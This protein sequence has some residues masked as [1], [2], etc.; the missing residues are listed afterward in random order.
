MKKIAKLLILAI[1]CT[2]CLVLVACDKVDSIYF[3]TEPR[4]NYVQGQDFTLE[5]AVLMA[6]SGNKKN[7]VNLDEATY[8]GYNPNQIGE[9]TVT[10][11]YEGQTVEIKVTVIP[12]IA[13]EGIT[14]DYFVGDNFD[15][16][17]GRLRV[18]DDKANVKSVNLSE[19]AV[20]IEGFD[21]STT[22]QKTLTVKYG[23]Y[24][25]TFAVNVYTAETVTLSSSPKQTKY[26]SHDTAFST[27]GAYFT[28][29]ANNGSLT[30]MVE[31]TSDMVEGFLPSAATME[32]MDSPL[33]QTVK[34][35]YLGKSF[36]FKIKVYF[37]AVSLAILR[38]EELKD[39]T[40]ENATLEQNEHALDALFKYAELTAAD[41]NL[42][43]KSTRLNSSH[44]T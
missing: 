20:I 22:G 25:G 9:Q 27:T 19:E 41:K 10:V 17:K 36:D 21:S 11:T 15:K 4:T 1:L 24:T 18:A 44:V 35:K 28:V 5:N 29:T 16:T 42:D 33:Q 31:V 12:R 34:I 13:L 23:E 37:S 32:N 14:R 30:R 8:S 39:V 40:P 6:T 43:R 26:Y 3:E 7:S 2:I 38:S